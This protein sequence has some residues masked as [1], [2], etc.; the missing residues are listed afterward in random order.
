[1]IIRKLYLNEIRKRV[2]EKLES[3]LKEFDDQDCLISDD[4]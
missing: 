3:N 1:M 4:L 2:N